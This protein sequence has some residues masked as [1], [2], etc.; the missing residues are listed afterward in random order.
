M[1]VLV[2]G[3]RNQRQSVRH[4]VMDWRDVFTCVTDPFRKWD[5]REELRWKKP[6]CRRS[7]ALSQQ[8]FRQM[9]KW[10]SR[11]GLLHGQIVNF[12]ADPCAAGADCTKN[13]ARPTSSVR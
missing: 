8:R 10:T 5:L 12:Q 1:K 4:S 2:H 9:D 3:S 13:R 7:L 11:T 6:E